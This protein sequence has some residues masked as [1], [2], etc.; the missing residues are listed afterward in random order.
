M[1]AKLIENSISDYHASPG[2]SKSMLSVLADCPAR[3]DWQY[4]KGGKGED[5]PSLR[6]GNAMHVLALEP[7]LF[8]KGYCVLPEGHRRDPRT[9]KHKEAVI[10][11]AGRAMIT[12]KEYETIYG[13]AEALVKS[14]LALWLLKSQ[15]RIESSIY[16]ES[17]GLQLRCR[18]DFLRNDGLI[19]DLKTAKSVKE[20]FFS[21]D[22]WNFHYDVSVAL[23]TRGYEALYGKKPADYVFLCI[24]TEPPYLI[25]AYNNYDAPENDFVSYLEAGS[26]RLDI[27]LAVYK[28]CLSKGIWPGYQG[29]ITAMRRPK[30][31]A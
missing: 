12:H 28:D 1:T 30:W 25:E 17:D 29:K 2:L 23:T 19:V 13:M 21:K 4:N 6:L 26:E 8:E 20:S 7:G 16:W 24:E 3:F 10:A 9:E 18:P 31:A 27:L 22:A 14:P 11:A 5:T 15:G